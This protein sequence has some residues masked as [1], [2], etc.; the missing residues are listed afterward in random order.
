MIET[1]LDRFLLP[2]SNCC[3]HTLPLIKFRYRFI[4]NEKI[5]KGKVGGNS[6]KISIDPADRN[7]LPLISRRASWPVPWKRRA[8][9][10]NRRGECDYRIRPPR[11]VHF[12]TQTRPERLRRIQKTHPS[13]RGGLGEPRPG[14]G[15]R[16]R[17]Q[18]QESPR[19]LRNTSETERVGLEGDARLV[20]KGHVREF[21]TASFPIFL[22][23]IHPIIDLW[24][25]RVKCLWR[26]FPILSS[27]FFFF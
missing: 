23:T 4:E 1:T 8:F 18:I 3:Y 5:R 2:P 17:Q 26:I 7:R 24:I 22:F 15:V 14:I 9:S 13:D 11:L 6:W 20:S 16:R 19:L 10:T 12:V 21:P 27:I 25:K